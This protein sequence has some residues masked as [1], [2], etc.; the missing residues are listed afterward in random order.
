MLS[1]TYNID[2]YRK[3]ILN[4]KP[5]T[6]DEEIAL[7]KKILKGDIEASNKLVESNLKFVVYTAYKYSS[8]CHNKGISFADLVEE[9]NLGLIKAARSFDY[10]KG[11]RFISYAIWWITEYIRQ[12]TYNTGVVKMPSKMQYNSSWMLNEIA[13]VKKE[14][15]RKDVDRIKEEIKADKKIAYVYV[16]AGV[17]SYEKDRESIFKN[18][19]EDKQEFLRSSSGVSFVEE[20]EHKQTKEKLRSALAEINPQD[21]IVLQELYLKDDIT[22]RKHKMNI[23]MYGIEPNKSLQEVSNIMGISKERV[24]QRKERGLVALRN[25]LDPHRKRNVENAFG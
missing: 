17:V 4:T 23:G 18:D 13:K 8:Y 20:L 2:L 16:D 25:I 3:Q 10:R 12:V 11:N 15:G 22:D 14:T 19:I 9:G 7:G 6:K 24:R 1:T 5:L 21:S